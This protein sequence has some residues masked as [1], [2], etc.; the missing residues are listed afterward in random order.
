MV[1]VHLNLRE[2]EYSGEK[3]AT[4]AAKTEHKIK[5]AC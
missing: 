2:S 1:K 5:I 3:N 4:F